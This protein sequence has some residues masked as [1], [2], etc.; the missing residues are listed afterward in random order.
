MFTILVCCM[1]QDKN[2]SKLN[3]LLSSV[4]QCTLNIY[5]L[6]LVGWSLHSY[7]FYITLAF[8]NEIQ[9]IIIIT[10]SWKMSTAKEGFLTS[11]RT[12]TR[13]IYGLLITNPEDIRNHI[14]YVWHKEVGQS[15]STTK[16]VRLQ[17]HWSR[18]TYCYNFSRNIRITR[19]S[20]L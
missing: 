11:H 6:F 3:N 18:K 12:T 4:Y 20:L 2:T 17:S 16:I 7:L 19:G 14:I 15:K 8:I 10:T 1:S 5:T 13:R 9:F